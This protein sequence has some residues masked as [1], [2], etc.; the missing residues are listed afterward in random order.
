MTGLCDVLRWVGAKMQCC[1]MVK[2]AICYFESWWVGGTLEG[3][4]SG[5]TGCATRL[6]GNELAQEGRRVILKYCCG[7]VYTISTVL[8]IISNSSTIKLLLEH[9][10]LK[11]TSK[12]EAW[13]V[14]RHF[15][16]VIHH[17]LCSLYVVEVSL[18]TSI[19][20]N[21]FICEFDTPHC[22]WF[23]SLSGWRH[24]AAGQA[25]EAHI[26]VLQECRL[27]T[28]PSFGFRLLLTP[29]QWKKVRHP[30]SI[31]PNRGHLFIL[32]SPA[33]PG[34]PGPAEIGRLYSWRCWPRL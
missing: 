8:Q 5:G 9:F 10:P 26:Q 11:F 33:N 30:P 19:W 24:I 18:W 22:P 14:Q 4:G 27:L 34:Y 29:S 3:Y 2:R 25:F 21:V 17:N 12:W 1:K 20:Q 15:G 32:T 7:P 28:S 13:S 16:T 23:S 31:R 6:Y